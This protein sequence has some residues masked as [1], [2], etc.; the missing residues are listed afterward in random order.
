MH[1]GDLLA[2]RRHWPPKTSGPSSSGRHRLGCRRHGTVK[3][4]LACAARPQSH[5]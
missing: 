4:S 5:S 3:H 1:L 2:Q